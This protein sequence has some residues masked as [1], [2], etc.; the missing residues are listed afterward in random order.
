[1]LSEYPVIDMKKTGKNIEA[2]R[3]QNGLFVRDLQDA[4]GFSSC[5]AIYIWQW[6]Q[7]L[8]NIQNLIAL[9]KI[10]NVTIE[11]ILVTC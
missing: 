6:G 5:Q 4:L 1:M 11:E 8:P 7:T 10:F 3:K 2:L 9:S